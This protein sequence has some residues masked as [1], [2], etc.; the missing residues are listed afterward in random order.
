M[1]SWNLLELETPEGSRSPIVLHSNPDARAV[2]I[3][4]APGQEL[5]DHQVH[6]NAYIVVLDG[7][8][9]IGS[10]DDAVEAGAGTLFRFEAQERHRVSSRDGA[11]ILL[12]LAPWPGPGHYRG[13]G[14]GG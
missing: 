14:V 13:G 3:E 5:G 7:S 12:L 9:Q 10:G 11:R 4:L 6:E 2:L 1:Q 8:A